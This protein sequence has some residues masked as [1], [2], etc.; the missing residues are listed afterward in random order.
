M[1]FKSLVAA[2]A[3]TAAATLAAPAAQAG[4]VGPATVFGPSASSHLGGTIGVGDI[5]VFVGSISGQHVDF[6]HTFTFDA[7]AGTAY[8]AAVSVEIPDIVGIDGL[9]VRLND[10]DWGSLVTESFAS[11]GSNTLEIK[12]VTA[13]LFGGNYKA[14]LAL[15]EVPLPGAVMLFGSALA[16]LGYMRRRRQAAA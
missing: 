11:A 6:H 14:D 9:M 7:D 16:G 13:G 3:L 10:G 15:S 12:G 4:I 8:A 1:T 5:G 2:L